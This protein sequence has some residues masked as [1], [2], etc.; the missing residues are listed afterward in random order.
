M[1][2]VFFLVGFLSF[3]VIQ[4]DEDFY[5][6]VEEIKLVKE[7]VIF[8]DVVID[9]ILEEWRLMDF[10]QRNLYKD[11]M[12]ENYRN[13]VFLGFV[14]FKLDM[15]FYLE[16]GKGLWVIMREI[17]SIFYFDMEFKFVIKNV[18]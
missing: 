10:I 6:Y 7:L 15:I 17:L 9:F 4:L 3:E 8:K 5:F 16:N 18:I 12:L 1:V 2:V 13:L 14:V 11:V